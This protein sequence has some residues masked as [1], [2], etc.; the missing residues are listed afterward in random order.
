[1]RPSTVM[2]GATWTWICFSEN[3]VSGDLLAVGVEVRSIALMPTFNSC[4]QRRDTRTGVQVP[5][6]E[7]RGRGFRDDLPFECPLVDLRQCVVQPFAVAER[8]VDR[9]I[10]SV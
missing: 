10:E 4:P 3:S 7:P 6:D 5:V 1:M 9:R 8:L 2:P